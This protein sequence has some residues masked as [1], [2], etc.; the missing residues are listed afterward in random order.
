MNEI[1]VGWS[2]FALTHSKPGTGNS[3]TTLT[4]KKVVEL[5]KTNWQLAKPGSGETDVTRKILVPVPADD[6]YCP[7]RAKLIIGMPIKAQ[8]VQRQEGEDPYVETYVS[9]RTARKFNAV[10]SVVAKSANIVCYSAEALLEN[11]GERSTDCDWEI[12]TILCDETEEMTPM[13]SLTMARNYLNKSGGTFTD[14]SAKEFAE[15]I[16]Y[17]STKRG[18]KIKG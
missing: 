9:M 4:N 7:P 13:P 6:F 12:V 15:S 5:V 10:E 18:I 11:D 8:I 2:Q 1:T 14:Y 3:Y 17:Q 16:W